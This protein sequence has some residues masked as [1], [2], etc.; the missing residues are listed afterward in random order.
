MKPVLKSS[1]LAA[2]VLAVAAGAYGAPP[3]S[4]PAAIT[5][6]ALRDLVGQLPARDVGTTPEKYVAAFLKLDAAQFGQLVDALEPPGTQKDLSVRYALHGIA[7]SIANSGE[8]KKA[9][10][11]GCS[12]RLRDKTEAAIK[13]FLI[14]QLELVG[15]PEAVPVLAGCLADKDT[16]NSAVRALVVIKGDAAKAALRTALDRGG[17]GRAAVIAGLGALQDDA[18][19]AK[20]R[21]C[22]KDADAGVRWAA[23]AA[24]ADIADPQDTKAIQGQMEGAGVYE[25][26]L[27]T[28]DL[29]KMAR[30][31]TEKK[32]IQ[33]ADAIY[34]AFW[35]NKTPE[36]RHEKIAGLDGL[37]KVRGEA[38]LPLVVEAMG[39]E[40][41]Q[42]RAAAVK[43]AS[44]VP[45]EKATAFWIEQLKKTKNQV[46]V[47][48]VI[49]SRK[50][51][52]AFAVVAEYMNAKDPAV[53]VA[54]IHAA[55]A[56]G[57]EKAINPILALTSNPSEN[58][59]RAAMAELST[60]AG[61]GA[62]AALAG[63][64]ADADPAARAVLL[65]LLGSRGAK[66]Q[67]EAVLACM[68]DGDDA[69]RLAAI[70]ALE[71][72]GDSGSVKTLI[73]V[74]ASGKPEEKAAAERV[75]PAVLR[76]ESDDQTRTAPLTAALE[77]ADVT[78]KP[79][80]LRV[81]S[82]VGGKE[83][84]ATLVGFI[85]DPNADILDAAVRSLARTTDPEAMPALL[86]IARDSKDEK[87]PALALLAY[88]RLL[89]AQKLP[90][91]DKVK[92]NAAAM[93]LARRP[94]DRR[95][96]MGGIG[97]IGTPGALETA[98]K[99]LDDAATSEE[100][101]TA[102]VAIA[103][104]LQGKEPEKCRAALEKVIAVVKDGRTKQTARDIM[105]AIDRKMK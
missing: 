100:S 27:L 32:M 24:L 74:L 70:S 54:A 94:E 56:S 8:N 99:Y 75:L 26:S 35:E 38:A 1:I 89:E 85:H 73:A 16:M 41:W 93:P 65:G 76:R 25:R 55:G 2:V 42:M 88:L 37:V 83:A 3:A 81:L 105:A 45:G 102:V 92:A 66:S 52:A 48:N 59:R 40:D 31:L 33:E 101:S 5:D 79:A 91:D 82:Q 60:L 71:M 11:E 21:T 47:L 96:I 84:V 86:E 6:P 4:V 64:L 63:R 98:A 30:R 36:Y 49:A 69:V 18:A 28:T 10:V 12:K 90:E 80:L 78:V 13:V 17:D 68:G 62:D 9:F 39:A 58:V 72:L 87:H 50:D 19:A 34:T 46:E 44:A 43:I 97:K 104:K 23:D 95:A 53:Q 20:I 29:L 67:Q 103:Q 77:K 61:A 51:P 22:I 7:Y 14:E 57:G 15:S